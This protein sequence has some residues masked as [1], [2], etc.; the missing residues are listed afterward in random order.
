MAAPLGVVSLTYAEARARAA[1][2][3]DVA[4]ASSSTS[5]RARP[6]AAGRRSPSRSPTRA[7]RRSSSCTAARTC[8]SRSTARRSSAG[9]R[10][11]TGSRCTTSTPRNEVVV[12]ARLPYVN[13]GDGM[14]TFTDPA[15]GETL[16]VGATRHGHR[17]AGLRLLRPARPQ[18]ADRADG[19]GRPA[20]TVVANGRELDARGRRLRTFTTTPPIPT[21][22]SS[23]AP[24]RGTRAPG[25]T[26]GCR[27]AGTPARR[28]PPS[29]TATSRSM[30][31]VTERVLRPLHRRLRRA[32]P[33]R[34]LRP[35]VVPGLNW[36]AMETP[37]CV[38][39]RD[40]YAAARRVTDA[41]RPATAAM[42]IAHEMAHM[43]FGDLV[44]MNLVG[45]H[46][47]QRVVR[48][49]HG[50]PGRRT[51]RLR[52]RVARLP[53]QPQAAG[54]AADRRRSTHPVA[55]A[56][57]TCPTSTPRPP[58]STRSPTQGRLGAAPAGHL[59]GRR[60]SSR[61]QRPPHPAPVRQRHL[62]D[63]LEALDRHRRDVRG[64][65]E[66]WLRRTGFDTI[67][68]TRDGDVPVLDRDGSGRTG[69]ASRRTTGADVRTAGSSTSAEPPARLTSRPPRR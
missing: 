67:R 41:E 56:P 53:G 10:R 16:R 34:L 43:W 4:Y 3:S 36:G 32:L 45:G 29:S 25:S 26:P 54:Y 64:W 58:T 1:Q 63:F 22:C 13:D 44:T 31:R 69:S 50:L 24:A 19:D 37:G 55:A 8:G 21:T 60:P 52:R 30:R 62:A 35:G 48:R 15:D 59:A 49:L 9:V 11:R 6:S 66:V 20:W 68:V 65:A 18:G 5:P 47:A 14:H 61:A 39:F 23:C 12:E 27:S 28:W 17:P 57:R 7:P 51:G 40:E 38:T 33:V 46:L 42:V 2:V